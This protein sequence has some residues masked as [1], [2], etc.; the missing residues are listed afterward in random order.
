MN[1]IMLYKRI[2]CVY[3]FGVLTW[4]QLL[5]RNMGRGN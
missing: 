1:N 4:Y 2:F 3:V 5:W